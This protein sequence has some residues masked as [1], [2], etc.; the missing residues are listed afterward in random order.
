M[1]R[2]AGDAPLR[3]RS[4]VKCEHRRSNFGRATDVDCYTYEK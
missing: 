1:Q 3:K 4:Y 2:E